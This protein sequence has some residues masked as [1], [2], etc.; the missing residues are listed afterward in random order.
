MHRMGRLRLAT[1]PT[2]ASRVSILAPVARRWID[3]TDVQ[4]RP[5]K[6]P[7]NYINSADPRVDLERAMKVLTSALYLPLLF[8]QE[9]PPNVCPL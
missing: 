3:A 8:P 7:N 2:T 4:P 1:G 6:E 5:V 9:C